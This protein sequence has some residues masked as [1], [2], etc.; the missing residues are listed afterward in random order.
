MIRETEFND[1][2]QIIAILKNIQNAGDSYY[3]LDLSDEE[4]LAY[5]THSKYQSFVYEINKKI[6]G[7]Y[8]IGANGDG[9]FAHIANASYIVSADFRGQGI[10]KLLCKHSIELAKS[11]GYKAIQF[12]RVVS[13]NLAAVTLWQSLGFEI[14]GT[15]KNGFNHKQLGLVD[16]YIMYRDLKN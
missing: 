13:T 5:W 11:Q 8:I 6:A 4:L 16:F 7:S 10:G 2:K 15:I 9:R 1:Y 12:N 14:I 3:F